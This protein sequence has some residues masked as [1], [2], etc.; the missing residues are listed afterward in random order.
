[1]KFFFS[2]FLLTCTI[3]NVNAQ[4]KLSDK[5]FNNLLALTDLYSHNNMCKGP[6]FAKSADS[7]RTPALNHMVDVLIAT[8]RADTSIMGKQFLSRPPHD[9][10]V[11]WYVMREVHYNRI[12]TAKNK[13]SSD[14]IAKNT[15]AKNIDERWLV[16]NY[17]YF[18][19]SGIAML[20][21]TA[22]L[23]KMNIDID[24]LG[25][26]DETE[27]GIFFLSIS[28]YLVRGRFMVL[29]HMKNYK[30]LMQ[31]AVKM[32]LFNGKSYFYFTD[33]QFP[34]FD[35]SGYSNEKGTY[36]ETHVGGLI[37]T[38]AAH[39]AALVNTGDKDGARELYINSILHKPEYFKY[40]AEKDMLQKIYDKSN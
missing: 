26:K 33:L 10:L 17:Y 11:L 8:G 32:P 34:D 23:S 24:G 27:K 31:Y 37:G 5:D 29:T 6:A 25:L 30:R 7:L 12:D 28:D 16:H 2:L 1:M 9:E 22:D 38:L 15:L 18:L 4:V 3:I 14:E 20:F 40:S 19:D 13:P 35:W 21:N 39:L 36:K